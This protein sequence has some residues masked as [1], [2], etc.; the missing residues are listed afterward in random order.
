MEGIDFKG[1]LSGGAAGGMVA[2]IGAL[3][4]LAF[5][6]FFGAPQSDINSGF[7]AVLAEMRKELRVACNQRDEFKDLLTA[8][9]NNT[10]RLSGEIRQLRA[11]TDGLTRLLKANGIAIPDRKIYDPVGPEIIETTLR[12]DGEEDFSHG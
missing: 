6:K 4:L 3:L 7:T 2:S 11:I 10:L 5:K 8:E 12:Q 1:I 9:R